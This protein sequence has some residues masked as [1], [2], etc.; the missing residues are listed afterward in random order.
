ME[1]INKLIETATQL[2][3]DVVN[4]VYYGG[5][6]HPGPSMSIID[7][8]TPLYFDIL[9]MKP[10]DP[11]WLNRDRFILSKGHACPALYAA[12][13]RRGYFAPVEL[14]KLRQLDSIVQGHP[15]PKDTP[16]VEVTAGSL[17][18]GLP[19]ACGMALAA[20]KRK[21][22]NVIF[23]LT[24]DGELN[25]GIV[26][27]SAMTVA[28]YKLTN[29]VAVVDYNGI[30]SGGKVADIS[31]LVNLKEKWAAFGW[32]AVE[33]DGH[34]MELLHT[35]FEN[36]AKR[37]RLASEQREGFVVV[38]GMEAPNPDQPIVFIAKTIKGKGLPFMEGNNAWH[39]KVPT[40]E[41]HQLAMSILGGKDLE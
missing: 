21:D 7:I 4:A 40:V 3:R 16:G 26:W 39:K 34:D 22:D 6:G 35:V 36:A 2:R 32:F 9:R 19:Q 29:I 13:A 12:L 41:E 17:G 15:V 18:H 28:K 27:E 33:I 25:E 1:K 30:Q 10:E 8:L 14:K 5:D 37:G 24:G 38:P 31:G 23:V 11:K 20:R